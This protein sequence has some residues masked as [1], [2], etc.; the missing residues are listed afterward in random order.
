MRYYLLGIIL[1]AVDQ[2]TKAVIRAKLA[3]GSSVN[4]LGELF[5]ITHVENRGAAFS[6]LEG[7]T[8]LLMIVTLA[9]I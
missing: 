2:L 3:V 4:V 9:I 6:I 1:L 7:K 8:G 5:R